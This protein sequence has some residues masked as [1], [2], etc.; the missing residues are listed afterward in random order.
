MVAQRRNDSARVAALVIAPVH[1]LDPHGDA[2]CLT[3]V[4]TIVPI[5][6]LHPD[7]NDSRTSALALVGVLTLCVLDMRCYKDDDNTYFSALVLTIDP[8]IATYSLVI[9][10]LLTLHFLNLV[11]AS[12]HTYLST[13]PQEFRSLA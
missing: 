2:L 11:P 3:I 9:V 8:Y 10:L 7:D 12:L 13:T 5:L 4:L 6:V 1:V